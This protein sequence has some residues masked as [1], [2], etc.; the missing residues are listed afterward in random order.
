MKYYMVVI[1]EYDN[2]YDEKPFRVKREGLFKS[3]REASQ[4][5]IDNEFS[6]HPIY[7]CFM[8]EFDTLY[9]EINDG[10]GDEEFYYADIEEWKVM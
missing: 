6:P 8:E 9:F 1:E 4:Y 2:K 5:L 10:L 7:D 3:Y